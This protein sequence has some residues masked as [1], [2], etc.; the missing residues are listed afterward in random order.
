MIIK[1]FNGVAIEIR[2]DGFFNLTQMAKAYNKKIQDYLRLDSTKQFL[3]ALTAR[4]GIV[5]LTEV[6]LG[7]KTPG[8]W[9]ERRVALDAARWMDPH[10]H[11]QV[12]EW[13]DE[14]LSGNKVNIHS[15]DY[16]ISRYTVTSLP[17]IDSIV[18]LIVTSP[19]VGENTS[20]SEGPQLFK[21]ITQAKTYAGLL[22]H[23]SSLGITYLNP[24]LKVKVPSSLGR[25]TVL[26][27]T[28]PIVSISVACITFPLNFDDMD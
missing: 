17:L 15:E 27:Y 5:E 22:A 25:R 20:S 28:P 14:I 9:G 8:T 21:P 11:V 3:A 19:S 18:T 10:F 12:I 26:Q 23:L 24:F 13:V 7:G 2:E 1:Q 16:Y 6:Y 4:T